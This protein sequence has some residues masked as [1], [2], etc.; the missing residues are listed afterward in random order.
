MVILRK[1]YHVCNVA[2]RPGKECN[3]NILNQTIEHQYRRIPNRQS[4]SYRTILYVKVWAIISYLITFR[5][6][7]GNITFLKYGRGFV[8]FPGIS[9]SYMEAT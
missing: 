1:R 7:A 2:G 9:R 3:Y 8:D 6:S 4:G 5:F